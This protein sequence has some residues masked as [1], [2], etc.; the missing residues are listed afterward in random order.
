M[1]NPTQEQVEAVANVLR[2]Q[3]DM[4]ADD[5]TPSSIQRDNGLIWLEGW[6]DLSAAIAA[7]RP[8]MRGEVAAWEVHPL[9]RMDHTGAQA[10]ARLV[11]REWLDRNP[12]LPW[13]FP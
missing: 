2:Y 4:Q 8:W 5:N 10:G 6:F 12:S 7:L 13:S 1:T 9:R 11:E 3:M